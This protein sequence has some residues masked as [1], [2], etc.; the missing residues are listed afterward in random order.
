MAIEKVK[1]YKS[2]TDKIPAELT[3]AGGRTIR[4][5]I[6]SLLIH[7]QQGGIARRV[8]GVDHCS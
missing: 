5:E 4:S 3:K 6:T 1:R 7:F 8:E 2:S